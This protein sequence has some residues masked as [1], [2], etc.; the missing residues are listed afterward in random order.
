MATSS[1]SSTTTAPTATLT[2]FF[3]APPKNINHTIHAKL[4]RDNFFVWQTQLP[5]LIGHDLLGSVN[6]SRQP[7]PPSIL[8]LTKDGT[9]SYAPNPAY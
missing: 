4:T 3:S 9:Q 6:G 8:V 1:S 5:F 7:P 2:S